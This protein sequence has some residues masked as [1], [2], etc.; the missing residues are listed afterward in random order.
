MADLPR[1]L[2]VGAGGH[3]R[4]IA[5]AIELASAY[6]VAGFAD[7]AWPGLQAVWEFPVLGG[8]A[9]CETLRH[10][11]DFAIVAIGNNSRRAALMKRLQEY[12]FPLA[13]VIHPSAQ[14]SRRAVVSE[15]SAIMATAVVGTE[16][17]LGAGVIVN[18]GA[19]VDHHCRV[20]DYGHLGVGACMSGGSMLG[21][22]AW[23]QAGAS[24]GYGARLA[25]GEI[26]HA[27]AAA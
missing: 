13:T 2:I 22:A 18:C 14:V 11:A 3:G 5:E 26:L 24:L 12:E 17:V 20:E 4:S 27:G 19:V 9:T 25:A 1:I 6:E 16:A 10:V 15:G 8:A 7:D 21:S 23:I